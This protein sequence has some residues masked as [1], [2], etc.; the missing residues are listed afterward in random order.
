MVKAISS[1][2]IA[3]L[4]LPLLTSAIPNPV[5]Y[6]EGQQ[7]AVRDLEDLYGREFLLELREFHNALDARSWASTKDE[8]KKI[9]QKVVNFANSPVGIEAVKE[10]FSLLEKAGKLARRD[11]EDRDLH[12]TFDA[13]SWTS[14]AKDEIK[15]VGQDVVNLANSPVGIETVKEG[16]SFL[17]KAGKF[18]RRDLEDRELHDAA[19]DS[20]SWADAKAEFKKVAEKIKNVATSPAGIAVA[21]KAVQIIG[22]SALFVRRDLEHLYELSARNPDDLELRELHNLLEARSWAG[23]KAELK[24]VGEKI[25]DV[26][27]SPAGIAVAE[28]AVKIIGESALFARRDFEDLNEFSARDLDDM[29]SQ[30]EWDGLEERY[31]ENELDERSW[32]EVKAG[33]K[34]VGH[35]I[36]KVITGPVGQAVAQAAGLRITASD[37]SS[38]GQNPGKGN[39]K[40][41]NGR[42]RRNRKGKGNVQAREMEDVLYGREF[43]I[44]ELD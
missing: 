21:E 10:G 7:R 2:A 24:K 39:G 5:V 26:A 42:G 37:G 38:S 12:D 30:R 28:K 25:K 14:S 33:I 17:E 22:E 13:R 27:T 11:L 16:F 31:L 43:E 29:L 15:K 20:R 40:R 9:S 4:L 1:V 35:K 23:A 6:S 41:S 36:K 34:R 32:D 3:F 44:N 8:F 18:A 19:F